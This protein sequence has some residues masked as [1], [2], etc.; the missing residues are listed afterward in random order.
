MSEEL[1]K[2]GDTIGQLRQEIEAASG[3][4]LNTSAFAL[5]RLVLERSG[6]IDLV[7]MAALADPAFADE[8]L[9]K[10]ITVLRP[11]PQDLHVSLDPAT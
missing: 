4:V 3:T 8:T 11:Q 7:V 10:A 2:L 9:Q 6:W 5:E 1:R